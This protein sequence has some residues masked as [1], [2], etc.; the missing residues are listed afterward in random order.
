MDITGSGFLPAAFSGNIQANA[1]C[2]FGPYSSPLTV[3]SDTS[4]RCSAPVVSGKGARRAAIALNGVDPSNTYDGIYAEFIV[5]LHVA[6]NDVCDTLTEPSFAQL[7]REAAMQTYYP[8]LLHQDDTQYYMNL[9]TITVTSDHFRPLNETNAIHYTSPLVR[10]S[11]L[12]GDRCCAPTS[13]NRGTLCGVT[14]ESNVGNVTLNVTWP[15][16]EP[17]AS[18]NALMI[19][20][21]LPCFNMP[22]EYH[23]YFTD[24]FEVWFGYTRSTSLSGET[25][26][27]LSGS[28][29]DGVALCS[30]HFDNVLIRGVIVVFDNSGEFMVTSASSGGWIYELELS[31]YFE[32]QPLDILLDFDS[33]YTD[34]MGFLKYLVSNSDGT[35]DGTPSGLPTSV[36]TLF[37]CS[38]YAAAKTQLPTVAVSLVGSQ[39]NL[40][41]TQIF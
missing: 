34:S 37:E 41:R 19:A 18:V 17:L 12:D 7:R 14:F 2:F 6:N 20:W 28:D 15:N 24:G 38:V 9:S 16:T 31:G 1:R 36:C 30:N 29:V 23:V 11:M 22:E 27:F 32:E 25:P 40:N 4:A 39:A 5:F 35:F 8:P 33:N 13:E 10:G 3:L 21:Y 26:C